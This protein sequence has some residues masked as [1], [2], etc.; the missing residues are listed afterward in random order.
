[1]FSNLKLQMWSSEDPQP[2]RPM[3][4]LVTTRVSQ[5][6]I[7]KIWICLYFANS[8]CQPYW[9]PHPCTI[10]CIF[11]QNVTRNMS[12]FFNNSL[13]MPPIIQMSH[14]K[15][16][17]SRRGGALATLDWDPLTSSSMGILPSQA[18]FQNTKLRNQAES[19]PSV[20]YITQSS[21]Q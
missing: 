13:S 14:N 20:L 21:P 10:P 12:G 9:R 15:I 7:L 4:W 2:R 1:M 11:L 17:T 8:C 6:R 18:S 3:S 19:F 5:I 16:T